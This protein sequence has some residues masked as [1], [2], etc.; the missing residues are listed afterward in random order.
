MSD[1]RSASKRPATSSEHG[2]APRRST[3]MSPGQAAARGAQQLVELT[4][5]E[6]EG[7]VGLEQDGDGWSVQVEVL[8]V[9]RIPNT[10]DVLAIYEVVVDGAGQLTSYRRLDRYM[11]GAAGEEGR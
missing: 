3:R 1:P 10:T 8:E 9:R 11:R 2:S 7:V 4:G 5:R 6:L